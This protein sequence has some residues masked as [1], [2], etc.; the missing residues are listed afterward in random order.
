VARRI[1]GHDVIEALANAMC[2]GGIPEHIR[3]D[4]D[5]ETI[6]KALRKSAAQ[7][8]P[9]IHDTA[10]GLPRE[11][12]SCESFNLPRHDE[13]LRK[14]VFRPSKEAPAVIAFG[15]TP[16]SVTGHSEPVSHGVNGVFPAG[17]RGRDRA[18]RAP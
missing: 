12:R 17:F 6:A 18:S 3:R 11:S 8:R 13:C 7:T 15:M 4:D 9:Q 14:E 10:P 5:P 2:L 16:A 1:N